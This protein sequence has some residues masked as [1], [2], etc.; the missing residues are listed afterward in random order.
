M[1]ID[2]EVLSERI[3]GNPGGKCSVRESTGAGFNGYF[4]FVYGPSPVPHSFFTAAHQPIYEAATFELA[5]WLGLSTPKTYVLL[6]KDKS[7]RF[8]GWKEFE[9]K[10][11]SGR[12][13][14]FISEL[15][16]CKL[17]RE[18]G[19]D[20][21]ATNIIESQKDYLE[22][23]RISDI[24]GKRQN[25]I[26][27]GEESNERVVYIDLGC[28]FVHAVGGM[29]K[30]PSKINFNGKREK[31]RVVDTLSKNSLI[32]S[33]NGRFIDLGEIEHFV[34]KMRVSTLNPRGRIALSELLETAEIEEI[35]NDVLSGFIGSLGS[36]RND[37]L[38]VT[39][40]YSIRTN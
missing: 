31:K 38:L 12:D 30:K 1:A 22:C 10:D 35:I 5:K 7:V 23:L 28:S 2:I 17:D 16:Q 27:C 18:K 33:D 21:K 34:D 40:S 9:K 39:N 11:P 24:V 29:L 37:G 25:Y 3:G 20:E 8:Y 14:Y 32:S 26:L 4:K 13:Y 36:L 19:S 15:L 6:N